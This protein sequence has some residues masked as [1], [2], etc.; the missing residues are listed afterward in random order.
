MVTVVLG[1]MMGTLVNSSPGFTGGDGFGLSLAQPFRQIS[2]VGRGWGDRFP[3]HAVDAHH[4]YSAIRHKS[5]PLLPT[6]EHPA[7]MEDSG[8]AL[9]PD[10]DPRNGAIAK[11]IAW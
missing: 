9:D 11:I 5:Q 1:L 8:D 3:C 2:L 10:V 4:S 7:L 6:V